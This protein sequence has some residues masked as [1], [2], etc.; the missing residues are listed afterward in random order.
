MLVIFVCSYLFAGSCLLVYVCLFMCVSSCLFINICLF[1]FVDYVLLYVLVRLTMC[2]CPCLF[3]HV[4]F[5]IYFDFL[6]HCLIVYV[7]LFYRFPVIHQCS[8]ALLFDCYL[9]KA[10]KCGSII[11]SLSFFLII[12]FV[13]TVMIIISKISSATLFTRRYKVI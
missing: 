4:C 1:M 12:L 11:L 10:E 8:C 6:F 2:V 7:R 9:K 5:I 13:N 3:G